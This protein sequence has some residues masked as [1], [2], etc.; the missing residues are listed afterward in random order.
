M[1]SENTPD[2]RAAAEEI[3]LAV[4][5]RL[6]FNAEYFQATEFKQLLPELTVLGAMG[7]ILHALIQGFLERWGEKGADYLSGRV[8]K[9]QSGTATP[10]EIV[11][12]LA[13]TLPMLERAHDVN[14][15]QLTAHLALE[16]AK[17]GLNP[18]VSELIAADVCRTVRDKMGP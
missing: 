18:S 7:V 12:G 1:A 14:W 16:L 8:Q 5:E 4:Y 2:R 9:W 6:T 3:Y 13:E 17:L 11:D 15:N 10:N